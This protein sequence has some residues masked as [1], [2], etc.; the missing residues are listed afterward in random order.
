MR[1][2][3]SGFEM[4]RGGQVFVHG[5]FSAMLD[6]VWVLRFMIMS[7][8]VNTYYDLVYYLPTGRA[9]SKS[10]VPNLLEKR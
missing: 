1:I 10:D 6:L 8:Q 3:I 4:G 7:V 2:V 9:Y 5:T